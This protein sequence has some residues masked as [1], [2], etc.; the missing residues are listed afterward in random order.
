[1]AASWFAN[2]S[3]WTYSLAALAFAWLAL[4]LIV[5]WQPGGKPAMLLAFAAATVL[6]AL[7]AV[8]FSAMPSLGLWWVASA[9][10]LLR[11]AA[12]LGFLLAFL[13][14][15]DNAKGAK[16]GGKGWALLV[17]IGIVLVLLQLLVGVKPPEIPDLSQ[18][19]HQI[20][21][22][23]AL[24]VAVFGL[25]LVEQCYRRTPAASRWHV[26]PLLLG[27]AGVLGFD[28]VL[29][30][31]ALLFRVLDVDLWAARGLAQTVT[32]PLLMLTLNAHE[33]GRS[34]FRY[35]AVCWRARRCSVRRAPICW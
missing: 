11:S 25:V 1:M 17:S 31:D 14:V 18:P 34:S 2:P 28:L 13:G 29:Y 3:V 22:A 9:F 16:R 12:T 32:V 6:A 23:A 5:Q 8:A 15:R 33:T 10:D 24:S 27:F 30:S 35:R 26:R 7:A 20:G 21:F 4:S 19:L